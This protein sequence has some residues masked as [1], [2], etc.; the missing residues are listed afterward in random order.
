MPSE[1]QFLRYEYHGT[2]VGPTPDGRKAGAP[3]ADSVAA[4]R[5]K[6]TAGPTAMLCSAAKLPQHLVE[7]ISV[8]NL[9]L[10]KD[11]VEKAL[12]PL[13]EGYFEMGGIQVQV[14][15][16]SAEELKAAMENPQEHQDLIVRVGGYSVPFCELLPEEQDEV[17]AR[18]CEN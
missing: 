3:T 8:L 12:Q 9:T 5:G 15:A 13:V 2:K 7:G 6:A 14:I 1:H 18:Y 11:N 4:L 10:Q 16:T 17:I